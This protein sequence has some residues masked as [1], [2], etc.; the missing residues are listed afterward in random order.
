[1]EKLQEKNR[2]YLNSESR[3]LIVNGKFDIF[4]DLLDIELANN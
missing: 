4:P 3:G 1:M 2:P